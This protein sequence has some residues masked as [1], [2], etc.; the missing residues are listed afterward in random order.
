MK[1]DTSRDERDPIDVLAA[2]LHDLAIGAN[3]KLG[4]ER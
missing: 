4:R 1:R 3:G 2:L